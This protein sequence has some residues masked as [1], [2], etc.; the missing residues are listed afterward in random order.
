MQDSTQYRVI[1]RKKFA[2]VMVVLLSIVAVGVWVSLDHLAEYA[3]QLENLAATET[4]E[5]AATLTQLLR[6]V[7]ILNGVVLSSLAI[8]ISWHGRRGWRAESMPPKGSWILEGQ[9]TWTGESAVRIAKFT[10]AVGAL[11]GVLGVTSSLVLWS[12]GDTVLGQTSKGAYIRGH[13]A[14]EL[15]CSDASSESIHVPSVTLT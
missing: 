14:N 2:V 3:E 12:L 7:A 15:S 1:D 13:E 5:A 9:R 4:A 11:L 6:T 8:L 10:I